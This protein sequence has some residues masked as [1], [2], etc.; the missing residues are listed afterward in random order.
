MPAKIGPALYP[1][2]S[3]SQC[4]RETHLDENPVYGGTNLIFY[5]EEPDAKKVPCPFHEK[6]EGEQIHGNT[7][8][9]V[10]IHHL[11]ECETGRFKGSIQTGDAHKRYDYACESHLPAK[12]RT[13][14]DHHN[15]LSGVHTRDIDA[16]TCYYCC[17]PDKID[18]TY[19]PPKK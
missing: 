4:A 18:P 6:E 16:A 2:K 3:L 8:P 1:Y 17:N 9:C 14:I 7:V 13:K 15:R 19:E 10:I 11:I 5:S 12:D